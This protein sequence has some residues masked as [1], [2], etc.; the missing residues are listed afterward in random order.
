VVE[1]HVWVV[2][3]RCHFY[4]VVF[5][6]H[7]L[8]LKGLSR[9]MLRLV[10]DQFEFLAGLTHRGLLHRESKRLGFWRL[11]LASNLSVPQVVE[12]LLESTLIVVG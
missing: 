6:E 4:L 1:F 8:V 11:E 10:I 12:L 2:V 7:A 5:H 3:E 9:D